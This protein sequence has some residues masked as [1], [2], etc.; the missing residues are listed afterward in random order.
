MSALLTFEGRDLTELTTFR[1]TSY[2]SQFAVVSTIEE[3][4]MLSDWLS[5]NSGVLKILGGGSNVI[6]EE[7]LESLVVHPSMKGIKVLEET[8]DHIFLEAQAGESWQDL[9]DFCIEQEWGGLENLTMIPGSVGAAP[10]QNIGAYGVQLSDHLYEVHAWDF[11]C[12]TLV[13]LPA[14]EC[15]LGY[16][17]S[18]FKGDRSG[19]WLITAIVVRLVRPWSPVLNY[20]EVRE[21]AV[22]LAGDLDKIRPQHMSEV[23]RR[24]RMKK[25]PDYSHIGNAGSFFKNPVVGSQTYEHLHQ[26]HPD[27]K[28]YPQD[29]GRWKL[30]AGW[31]IDRRGWKGYKLGAVGVHDQHALVL[32]NH[33]GARAK[34]LLGLAEKIQKDVCQSY[35]VSLE[36]EPVY[37]SGGA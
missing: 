23:I 10:V 36:I 34:D 12:G 14:N 32:V 21:E 16:R 22:S 20:A 9:V 5:N 31:L 7:N 6:L 18:R 30:A 15:D 4:Q 1:L 24:L 11:Q 26:Q 8:A 29:G 13:K 33:G 2:A 19:R 37:F 25:L 28:A 17:S 35:G 27:L 3:L